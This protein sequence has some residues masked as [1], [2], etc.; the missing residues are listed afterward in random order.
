MDIGPLQ[1]FDL[2][3]ISKHYEH[4]RKLRKEK[5]VLRYGLLKP[6]V[7]YHPDQSKEWHKYILAYA[8]HSLMETA[9]IATNVSNEKQEF[10]IDSSELS[11]LYEKT[12][13][14]NTVVLVQYWL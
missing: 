9:I 1:G 14:E 6:L 3:K 10:F 13:S 7:A 4:R 12:H 5:M 11:I 2:K 8:R